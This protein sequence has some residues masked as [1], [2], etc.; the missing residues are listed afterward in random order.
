M[1]AT[2]TILC[3]LAVL[4]AL[5]LVLFGVYFLNGS[6]EQFPTDEQQG[7]VRITSSL[8]FVVFAL[9]ETVVLIA[10]LR[11]GKSRLNGDATR[12]PVQNEEPATTSRR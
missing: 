8:G 11:K 1:K 4:L 6:L 10:L 12:S 7:A 2:R 9:L 5:P 3:A